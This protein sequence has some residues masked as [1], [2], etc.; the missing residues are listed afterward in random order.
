MKRLF[1][2]TCLLLVLPACKKAAKPAASMPTAAQPVKH[3]SALKLPLAARIPQDVETFFGTVNLKMHL[4]SLLKTQ[5]WGKMAALLDEKLP[6]SNSGAADATSFVQNLRI[7]DFAIAT[8]AGTSE[9]L[10]TLREVHQ[11]YDGSRYESLIQGMLG[12]SAETVLDP[13]ALDGL[14]LLLERFEIPNVIVAAHGA[15]SH[16]MLKQFTDVLMKFPDFEKAPVASITTTQ[17]EKMSVTEVS[18]AAFLTPELRTAWK[19]FIAKQWPGLKAVAEDKLLRAFDVLADK[20]IVIALARGKES[21]FAIVAHDKDQIRLA[22]GVEDSVLMKPEMK[23]AESFAARDL[24]AVSCWQTGAMEAAHQPEATLSIRNG[25]V[26]AFPLLAEK[27]SAVSVAERT[28]LQREFRSGASVL[29]WE[30]GVNFESSGGFGGSFLEPLRKSSKFQQLLADEDVLLAFSGHGDS[31]GALREYF[32][33]WMILAQAMADGL[34]KSGLGGEQAAG[35]SQLIEQGVLPG[36]LEM[37]EASKTMWQKGLASDGAFILDA[38]GRMPPLPGLPPAGE[39]VPLPRICSVHAV[40]NRALVATAWDGMSS[41]LS[42]ALKAI[43]APAPLLLPAPEMTQQKELTSW[44]YPLSFGS[45][46][47]MP[48]ASISDQMLLWGTSREQQQDF[49]L[50][51][52]KPSSQSDSGAHL[53]LN[54]PKVRTL[55]QAFTKARS[56]GGGDTAGLEEISQWLEPLGE[57]NARNW[58]ENETFRSQFSWKMHDLLNY[59]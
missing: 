4:E 11:W 39:K 19:S 37:Y 25:L 18:S 26:S 58:V 48:C 5:A 1:I 27:S 46:D 16:E 6:A 40:T 44:F 59:N 33:S 7:D 32:E 57:I 52:A 47:L 13:V 34:I 30:G 9:A 50:K 2:F 38:G 15:E 41:G 8:G 31:T 53:R 17:G 55:L 45:G 28:L 22:E 43:P 35:M 14:I 20:N 29:W 54:I 24:I 23:F 12:K 10:R 3:V 21:A 36:V 56:Q 42:K 51:L 49:A